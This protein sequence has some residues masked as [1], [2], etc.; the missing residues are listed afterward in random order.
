MSCSDMPAQHQRAGS[1]VKQGW[2]SCHGAAAQGGG[3][4]SQAA[5]CPAEKVHLSFH[6]SLARISPSQG[7]TLHLQTA[8]QRPSLGGHCRHNNGPRRGPS[9][10][11]DAK[12]AV[13][14]YCRAQPWLPRPC[15][16]H[17]VSQQETL[18]PEAKLLCFLFLC[19]FDCKYRASDSAQC[20]QPQHNSLQFLRNSPPHR[21][22]RP[23]VRSV[24][25]S[26]ALHAGP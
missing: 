11:R 8:G 16:L 26:V 17:L 23:H 12:S 25:S 24:P 19:P 4:G 3:A 15:L 20:T 13:G 22:L 2:P 5:V 10:A 9:A 7:P 14:Y 18:M 1:T 21:P 6:C